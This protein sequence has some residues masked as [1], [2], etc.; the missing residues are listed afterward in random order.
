M[1]LHFHPPL[2][3]QLAEFKKNDS[4]THDQGPVTSQRVYYQQSGVV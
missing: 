3:I 1:K 2:K 4:T